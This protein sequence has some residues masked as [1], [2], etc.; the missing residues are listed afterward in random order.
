[1]N[2]ELIVGQPNQA[3]SLHTHNQKQQAEQI[4]QENN[5]MFQRLQ[6][7]HIPMQ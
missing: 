1:M 7:H 4:K 3:L 2:R 5:H 6:P